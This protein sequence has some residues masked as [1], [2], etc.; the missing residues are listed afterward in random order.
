MIPRFSEVEN[1]DSLSPEHEKQYNTKEW[2]PQVRTSLKT[3]FILFSDRSNL[4][5]KE[6]EEDTAEESEDAARKHNKYSKAQARQ[7][8]RKGKTW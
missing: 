2:L 1:L 6:G 5:G 7:R 8:Y 3:L 4:F